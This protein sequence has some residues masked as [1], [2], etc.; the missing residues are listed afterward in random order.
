LLLRGQHIREEICEP[1][2]REVAGEL[3]K[4]RSEEICNLTIFCG[5]IQEHQMDGAFNTLGGEEK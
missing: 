1:K 2:K 4:F 5:Q 3:R